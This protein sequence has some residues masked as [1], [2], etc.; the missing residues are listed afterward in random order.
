MA[1]HKFVTSNDGGKLPVSIRYENLYSFKGVVILICQS[2]LETRRILHLHGTAVFT[3]PL[4]PL[5]VA[6]KVLTSLSG[7]CLNDR[8]GNTLCKRQGGF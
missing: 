1:L 3:I 7:N 5:S 2:I 6:G 8:C 4:S